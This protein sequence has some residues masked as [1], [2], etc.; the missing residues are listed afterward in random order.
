MKEQ[1]NHGV[2][3][4]LACA[5]F[6]PKS[7]RQRAVYHG[8]WLAAVLLVGMFLLSLVATSVFAAGP[9]V[10]S[11]F[12]FAN[13]NT[14]GVTL[15]LPA[16]WTGAQIG[17]VQ[18]YQMRTNG[19][20]RLQDPVPIGSGTNFATFTNY[21]ASAFD[22]QPGTAY[23][24]R[25]VFLDNSLAVIATNMVSV[26]T[27]TDRVMGPA[28]TEIYVATNGLDSNPG[29]LDQPKATLGAAFSAAAAGT[30]IVM[31]GG[32]YREGSL[33]PPGGGTAANPL[34]VRAYADETPILDGSTASLMKSGWVSDGSGYYHHTGVL[35]MPWLVAWRNR[36]S[37]T[38][39]RMYPIATKAELDGQHSGA[40]TFA[41]HNITGAY[42]WDGGSTLY[43]W[44]P[45]FTPDNNVDIQVAECD[46]AIDLSDC[47]W[48]TIS[49]LTFQFYQG[50][51]VYVNTASDTWI[52]GCTF[53]YIGA[54]IGLKRTSDRL[55]VENCRFKDDCN[56][57]G[58][59]PKGPDGY[60]YSGMIECGAVYVYT[61]YDGRGLVFRNNT[62]GGL[63]DGM[64]LCPDAFPVNVSSTSESDFYSNTITGVCDD[65]IETDGY[66]V[67]AR[68]FD[69]V[70]ENCLSGISIAQGTCG[71]L[72]VIRNVL[73]HGTSM[74]VTQDGYEGYP[75]K[76]NGGNKFTGDVTGWAYFYHNTGWTPMA[77]TGAFRVQYADWRKLFLANNIW[78]GTVNGWSVWQTYLDPIQCD[79][80][81][82]Y[83][84]SGYFFKLGSTTYNSKAAATN[85]LPWLA[86]A[87]EANP[88][89]VNPASGNYHLA[90][91]SPAIDAGVV[92]AGIN[93][94]R[95]AGAAP[96]CGAYEH[97]TINSTVLVTVATSPAGLAVLVNST[98][99]TAPCTVACESNSIYTVSVPSPQNNG[100][101]GERYAFA[102]WSDGGAQTHSITADVART[103]TASF[104][105]QYLLAASAD[106][107]GSVLPAN[108]WY[109]AGSSGSVTAAPSAG[110]HFT[111][112]SGDV[113][114][115]NANDNPV[116][117]AMD[118]AR[119]VMANFAINTYTLT[120][121]AGANGTVGGTTT[122]VV[123]YGASGTA[124]TALPDAGCGFTGWSDGVMVNPRTDTNVTG[125]ITV[126]AGFTNANC[127]TLVYMAGADGAI[128][129][130]SPQ[131]VVE[132]G[133]GSA[134]TAV[135]DLGCHFVGWSD[136][137]TANPRT[138]SGVTSSI[139]VA[140]SFAPNQYTLIYAADTGGTISGMATQTVNYGGSGSAVTAVTN[141]GYGFLA[142]SDGSTVNPR[143]DMNVASNI[144]VMASFSPN[145]GVR[146]V[147]ADATGANNGMSWAHAYTQLTNA[148][149]HAAAGDEIWVAAGTYKPGLSASNT[150]ALKANVPVYGGF[151]GSETVRAERDWVANVT[152]LSGEIGNAGVSDNINKIVTG[153]AGGTLDGVRLQGGYGT[154]TGHGA[155]VANNAG[156]MTVRNCSFVGNY[157]SGGDGG[158]CIYYYNNG[159]NALAV[160]SCAFYGNC[161]TG[162]V[163]NGAV[164]L[165]GSG[166]RYAAVRNCLFSGNIYVGRASGKSTSK[167][168]TL[169]SIRGSASSGPVVANCTFVSNT[170]GPGGVIGAGTAGSSSAC[171]SLRNCIIRGGGIQLR[172]PS[173][174]RVTYKNCAVPGTTLGDWT[175]ISGTLTDEGGHVYGDPL[176]VDEAGADHIAGTPDDDLHLQTNS[177]CKDAGTVTD[178][179]AADFEGVPRPQGAG[180]DIG[181]YEYAP[182]NTLIYIAGTN[183]AISG[184][185][186]QT[187]RQGGS[188]T[189]VTA[190]PDAGHHF[191]DWSDGITNNP[192]ADLS[193]TGN[194]G[195][196]AN[197]EVNHYTLAASAGAGGTINPEG[198]VDVVYGDGRA[199]AI[200]A[201]EH[202]GIADVRVD[203][204]SMGVTDAC[205]FAAVDMD[206]TI[207]ASFVPDGC[208][209]EIISAHGV[210]NPPVGINAGCYGAVLTNGVVTPDTQGMT[211]YVCTG[212]A[213]AGN[214][215]LDGASASMVMTVTNNAVLSWLWK[216]QY[217]LTVSAGSGGSVADSGG[218]CDGG[219]VTSALASASAGHSFAGWSGDVMGL[220]TN[221]NPVAVP[222]DGART[223][224][225]NFALGT[226]TLTVDSPHG[227]A[228][229]G[230]VTTNWGAALSQFITNT[231]VYEG[232]QATQYVCVGA[233][234]SG[235]AFTPDSATHVTLELTNSATL[236][237]IW[238]TNYWLD[239]GVSGSGT[240]S[241]PD[242]WA[243]A[244]SNVQINAQPLPYWHFTGWTGTLVSADNPLQLTMTQSCAVAAVFAMNLTTNADPVPEQWLADHGLTNQ[245]WT[246]EALNDQDKDGMPT[247]QEWI[248]DT[249]PT[250][251]ASFLGFDSFV[252]DGT[253][254][255]LLWHGGILSTQY[256]ERAVGLG[257]NIQWV[258]IFTNLPPTPVAAEILE[259][260]AT[261]SGGSYRIRAGR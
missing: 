159:T 62:I 39:Y 85:A 146:Y 63:F 212:W 100:V 47:S 246:T 232:V 178:A 180:Y 192:R 206:H 173:A 64:H 255:H 114:A 115:D 210:P 239:T 161:A 75:V 201:D 128:S 48:V 57:W 66:P 73:R 225:A 61:P 248:A 104:N 101:P 138:D 166:N 129:G 238:T 249:D 29:T 71:P 134:V 49:G 108:A 259:H 187:V 207:A 24:F 221:D 1:D 156:P 208:S 16:G 26:T 25:G 143:T 186:P 158:S 44:C 74:A 18:L 254:A 90:D 127:Y 230:T 121:A 11:G 105:T 253:D 229:P 184:T 130:K 205:T 42:Y 21:A 7:L 14:A 155:V 76:S 149:A 244:G 72:Y 116:L 183:G 88:N 68:I 30:H 94:E 231:A 199:F 135:P 140:A 154:G 89:L 55:L 193:V 81:F 106:V 179:P 222:M 38:V 2:L 19:L 132:N 93:D 195:V 133:S 103:V 213:M 78:C 162:A 243:G 9:L 141:S 251:P 86:S 60:D 84:Q 177:P 28:V 258:V 17:G 58:F 87:C 188:G 242:G 51:G 107:N 50:K 97:Y 52:T 150:F 194:I 215:P 227:G 117:L 189:A 32:I 185:S 3:S 112:W 119:S 123:S 56:R 216:T 20:R 237:W 53:Q 228:L 8:H 168:T 164:V 67:N 45:D 202:Y 6:Y 54:Y 247:W 170:G 79:N 27:R 241:V 148:L 203:G 98:S 235:N 125:N 165:A 234:V 4:R 153:V 69:N 191:V 124:V 22:L 15:Q 10:C 31:R 204:V 131:I 110:Y 217:N 211:Q 144:S 145:A 223:L 151:K 96:D 160:E 214:D 59:L 198:V 109:A 163:L 113:P 224:A 37:G 139:R 176:L 120:Y 34:V 240:V 197:F 261:N 200:S 252:C 91:N 126:S 33:T 13:Y 23:R 70:L 111:G 137:G 181:A 12:G 118:Q 122:Q 236:T 220:N 40:Y 174:G 190:V 257:S 167:S 172:V 250:N 35:A 157:A 95:Y 80:D 245:E 92:I 233:S 147:K 260:N 83:R 219:V 256:L 152:V 136:G 65:F 171:L 43:I 102:A 218:W 46:T 169:A 41:S 196:T 77:N 209:L 175:S 142:W 182:S 99:N 226:C 82:I 36:D 5:G